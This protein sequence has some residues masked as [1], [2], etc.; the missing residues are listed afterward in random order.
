MQGWVIVYFPGGDIY[1]MLSY[2]SPTKN[3]GRL[4]TYA[5]RGGAAAVQLL[6]WLYALKRKAKPLRESEA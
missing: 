5:M 2:D 4:G 1:Q 6:W 3:P